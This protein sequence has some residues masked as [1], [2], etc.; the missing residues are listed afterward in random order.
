M[1]SFFNI[2]ES[3]NLWFA[4]KDNFI[5]IYGYESIEVEKVSQYQFLSVPI[6]VFLVSNWTILRF[7]ARSP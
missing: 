5:D 7:T 4:L 1:F 3:R 2:M 6:Y